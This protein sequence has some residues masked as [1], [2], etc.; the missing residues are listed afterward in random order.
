VPSKVKPVP[1]GHRTVTPYLALRNAAKALEFYKKAFGAMET[2][3][4]MVPDG[5]V[6]HAEIRLGILSSCCRMNFRSM[7]VRRRIPLVGHL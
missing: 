6:G 2:Y 7:A 5:S 1:D 4:L 3:K